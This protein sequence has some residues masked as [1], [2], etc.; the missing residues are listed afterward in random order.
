MD[1]LSKLRQLESQQIY[2]AWESSHP[3]SYLAH[4]FVMIGEEKGKVG[5]QW[6]VG[7]YNENDTMTTFESMDD[8]SSFTIQEDEQI[9]KEDAERI[10]AVDTK[11]VRQTI[12]SVAALCHDLQEKKYP[13]ERPVKKVMVLQ[14]T[15]EHGL[16]VN[17]TYVTQTFKTLNIKVDAES[18]SIREDGL[19]DMFSFDKGD[20]K[21]E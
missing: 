20:K 2:K 17:V 9:F 19:H 1:F 6:Q 10:I 13:A 15:K 18:G 12:D 4:L 11:H 3:H 7:Y 21:I 14:A 16:V 5:M 8:D